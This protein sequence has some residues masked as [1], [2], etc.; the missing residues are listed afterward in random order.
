MDKRENITIAAQYH[1]WPIGRQYPKKA[2]A[3]LKKYIII[4]TKSLT[5]NDLEIL[6][7]EVAIILIYYVKIIHL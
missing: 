7:I 6:P 3:Q 4:P 5:K 2:I 1:I